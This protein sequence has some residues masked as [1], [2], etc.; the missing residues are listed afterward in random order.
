ML[1]PRRRSSAKRRGRCAIWRRGKIAV[2]VLQPGSI[3]SD[4]NPAIGAFAEAQNALNALGRYGR[5]EEIAAGVVFLASPE[6][7][8]VTGTVL[9]VDGGFGAGRRV[10]RSVHPVAGVT[11]H[12]AL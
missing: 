5:P 1:P 6:A 4:M 9:N 7:T 11:R 3:E 10:W 12:I 8:Y 2:N